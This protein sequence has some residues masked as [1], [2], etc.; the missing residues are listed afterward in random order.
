MTKECGVAPMEVATLPAIA[1]ATIA[2][3][4]RRQDPTTIATG[5]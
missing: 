5:S 3:T 1:V 2:V 4:G